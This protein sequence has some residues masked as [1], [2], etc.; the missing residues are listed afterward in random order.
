MIFP[1]SSSRLLFTLGL[2][3]GKSPLSGGETFPIS[4]PA[5]CCTQ[6]MVARRSSCLPPV[7]A[8]FL[9]LRRPFPFPC[10]ALL[11]TIPTSFLRIITHQSSALGVASRST[12][13]TYSLPSISRY[14]VHVPSFDFRHFL[15]CSGSGLLVETCLSDGSVPPTPIANPSIQSSHFHPVFRHL[16]LLLYFFLLLPRLSNFLS[17]IHQPQ[18]FY[19][20]IPISINSLF[21]LNSNSNQYPSSIPKTLSKYDRNSIISRS[22]N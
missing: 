19:I 9:H 14:S 11:Q 7:H 18:L 12:P 21:F 8:P 6:R 3:C 2:L 22:L 10:P 1:A 13:Y 5:C 20:I 15:R 4:L 17:I 16:L